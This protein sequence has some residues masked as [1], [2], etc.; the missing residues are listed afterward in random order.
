MVGFP[1]IKI[2]IGLN[3]VAK[4]ADGFHN[5]ESIFYPIQIFD[6]IEV[7]E[8]DE[9]S[10][11]ASGIEIPGEPSNNLCLKAYKLLEKDFD[12]PKVQINLHKVIP[13]GAGL[14][15]GS[16]DAAFTL[17]L[18]NSKFDL[19]INNAKLI[20]YARCLGSDCAFFIENTPKYCFGKGDEFEPVALDLSAYRLVIVYP[21][22]HISTPEAYSGVVPKP[23]NMALKELVKMPIGEW[24]GNIKND[25]EDSLFI[26]YPVLE[27]IKQALYEKGALYASMSGS[28]S[29]IYGIF[30]QDDCPKSFALADYKVWLV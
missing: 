12:I 8:S 7:L 15:G 6:V 30:P 9:L 23:S 4:R 18:L 27:S 22:L 26:K 13:I 1:N 16:A 17:K 14:G 24:K 28:G 3:I 10:F 29:T 20:D 2:N 25:F 11:N 5:I 19:K 21:N